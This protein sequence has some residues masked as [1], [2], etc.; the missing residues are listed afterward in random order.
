MSNIKLE[1]ELIKLRV[2]NTNLHEMN[3]LLLFE[4]SYFKNENSEL[5][6][7][8][9]EI[10]NKFLNSLYYDSIIFKD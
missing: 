5:E 6:I 10:V 8:I 7:Q 9:E 3:E 1:A 4:N 2:D